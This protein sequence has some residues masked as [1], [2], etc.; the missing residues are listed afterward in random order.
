MERYYQ[1]TDG[2][3]FEFTKLGAIQMGCCDCG[4]VHDFDF[5]IV[6]GKLRLRTRRNVRATAYLRK[7]D[8]IKITKI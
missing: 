5:R 6:K 3:W 7:K 2:E 4:L 1:V 8:N